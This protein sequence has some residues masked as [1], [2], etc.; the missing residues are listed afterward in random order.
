MTIINKPIAYYDCVEFLEAWG[1]NTKLL[2][3]VTI[4]INVDGI[5]IVET[6]HLISPDPNKLQDT[7]KTRFALVEFKNE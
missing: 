4:H 7:M 6:E 2:R 3:K 1:I 5:V